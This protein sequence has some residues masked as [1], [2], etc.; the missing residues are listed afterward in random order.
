MQ[1]HVSFS[2]FMAVKYEKFADGEKCP[3]GSN[4][5][6][7]IWLTW[8]FENKKNS[9]YSFKAFFFFFFFFFLLYGSERF[10]GSRNYIG[11]FS[12]S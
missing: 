2:F 8:Q 5:Y 1:N 10:K 6:P 4:E 3:G 12:N 11:V 7:T 9:V